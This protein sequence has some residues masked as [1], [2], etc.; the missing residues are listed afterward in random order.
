MGWEEFKVTPQWREIVATTRER[1]R[2]ILENLVN[3]EHC[4][5]LERLA[6]LQAEFATCAW[7]LTFPE[8]PVNL[9]ESEDEAS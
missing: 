9:E 4:N 7:L 2:M 5:T 8:I 3:P 6:A 1:Q